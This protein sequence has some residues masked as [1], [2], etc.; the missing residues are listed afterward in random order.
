MTDTTT[1]TANDEPYFLLACYQCG[2]QT[3]SLEGTGNPNLDG[4]TLL[5][6]NAVWRR[7]E[8]R[9]TDLRHGK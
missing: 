5:T 9:F 2:M 1:N 4:E 7:R 8:G 3:V 6:F